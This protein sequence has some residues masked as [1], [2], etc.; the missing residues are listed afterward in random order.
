M[1]LL[2]SKIF[3][4]YLSVIILLTALILYFSFE[5]IRSHYLS[6][7]Y[8]N[9][10][11]INVILSSKVKGYV[12]EERHSELDIIVKKMGSRI[13]TRITII[14]TAGVVLAD[15]EKN[16]ANM[17]NHGRRPEVVEA[18]KKDIGKSMRFSTTVKDNMLYLAMPIMH[19]GHRIGISRVSLF[20]RDVNN[21]ISDLR[22]EIIK[23]AVIVVFVS[24]FFVLVF[25]RTISRPINLLSKASFKTASGDF[26]SKVYLKGHDE[27]NELAHNFNYMIDKLKELFEKVTAQKEEYNILIKSIQEGLVVLDTDGRIALCN[28]GFDEIVDEEN[29]IGRH[30]KDLIAEKKFAKIY[31]KVIKKR[32]SITKEIKIGNRLYLCS[33]SFI[34]TKNEVVLLL[35]DIT[36]IKQ[37]EMI[38]RDFVVNVSHE[39]RTP[40]TSIKGFVETIE[41]EADGDLKNYAQI[42]HRNTDR[43]INIVQDLLILSEL[44][45]A[46]TQLELSSVS[47]Q[48]LC[49]N[50]MR[51]LEQKARDKN[52]LLDCTI[53]PAMPKIEADNYMLEQLFINLMDNAIKY[54]DEGG[55]K[56]NITSR[57]GHA[58]ITISDTGIG[59]PRKDQD[60]IFERFYTV[61]KSRSRK[62]GGT[63][64][65][66]SIVKHII[67]MHK[68]EITFESAK[69]EGTTFRIKI[70][71]EQPESVSEEDDDGF[72]D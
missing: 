18:R 27:I 4:G 26:D 67:L 45:D 36:E 50:V 37:L 40:L 17:E 30:F 31:K 47:L 33:G 3:V 29:I 51:I 15:S 54:T 24:L 46:N 71:I 66:L 34:E 69:N 10:E 12:L 19:N 64:L 61:D 55:V 5:T 25:S 11:E 7:E 23:V 32:K 68:G 14:D 16:P 9:L 72:E 49:S 56:V 43:L 42:I 60:R 62:V 58:M 2:S 22:Y 41:D 28:Q 57:N 48:R 44:E 8:A 21:L 59:I 35:H 20:M 38:K 39:L 53:D 13:D 52:I 63:G 1:K 65:G 70:P 6:S